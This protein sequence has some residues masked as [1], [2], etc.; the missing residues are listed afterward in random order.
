MFDILT[1]SLR[2]KKISFYL[3]FIPTIAI[4]GSLLFHNMLIS[5]NFS[6]VKMQIGKDFPVK[7]ICTEENN[8]CIKRHSTE[9]GKLNSCDRYFLNYKF[10]VDGKHINFLKDGQIDDYV[11]KNRQSLNNKEVK[12]IISETDKKQ[13]TCILNSPIVHSLYKFFP[14]V[15]DFIRDIKKNDNY[16]AA[17]AGAVNPLIYGETS[18]SNMVKR[19]PINLLF[20]PLLYLTSVLMIL[21][22]IYYQKIFSII[23]KNNNT[24]IFLIFG[25]ISGTFLFIHVFFLGT[26]NQTETF[27]K[28]RKIIVLTFLFAELFAQFF[29][30]RKIYQY[31]DLLLN[32][33]IKNI[34][35]AKIYFV[36]II[37]IFTII[38]I[39]YL[40]FYKVSSEFNNILEWN[41][42]LVLL[43]FYLLSSIM[44]KKK[45]TN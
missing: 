25:I 24:N 36:A 42:F 27:T 3:F 40:I 2:L 7:L 11:T 6:G 39:L 9:S 23:T 1:T 30:V 34:L 4:L 26:A 43:L 20:K 12:I 18:I 44:W 41:Y 28:I 31:K 37:L 5:Y 16:I 33:T 14:K 35:L 17:T 29:L 45:I 22:W 19:F 38:T 10:F 21:Y 8:Y 15:F 32:F 13:P